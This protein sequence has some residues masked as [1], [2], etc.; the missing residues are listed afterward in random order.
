MNV[1]EGTTYLNK[2]SQIIYVGA[3]PPLEYELDL[4]IHFQRREY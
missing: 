4:G 3:F 2:G 1:G